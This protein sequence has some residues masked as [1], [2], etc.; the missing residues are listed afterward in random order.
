MS[1][2]LYLALGA[3]GGLGSVLRFLLDRTVGARGR[4]PFPSGTLLVNLS[5]SLALGV[6]FGAAVT[7]TAYALLATGVLG[8]YT[9]FSTWMFESQRLAEGGE[10]GTSL[11]NLAI[12]LGGGLAAVEIG[13]LLGGA[14]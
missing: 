5:G 14:L 1:L 11:A 8:G 10:S 13:R 3:A 9:T 2:G 12:S 4:G 7:G 6:L